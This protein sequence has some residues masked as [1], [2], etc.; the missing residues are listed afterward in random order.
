MRCG[1]PQPLLKISR[2]RVGLVGQRHERPIGDKKA[3]K[4]YKHLYEQM[5]DKETIWQA[6]IDAAEE[7]TERRDVMNALCHIDQTCAET[8]RCIQDPDWQP[9]EHE[10]KH[11]VDGSNGKIREI[12]RPSFCVEQ[13][14]H[15]ALMAPFKPIVLHGMYE[16]VYGSLPSR[17]ITDANGKRRVKKY[18]PQA[19]A[20]QLAKWAQCGEKMF[21]AELDIMGAYAHVVKRILK[22]DLAEAI[23]DPPYLIQMYKCV[24]HMPNGLVLGFYPSPWL[25]NFYFDRFDHWA[26]EF[27]VKYLRYADNLYFLCPNKRRLHRIVAEVQKYLGKNMGMQLKYT[28]Q[29]Y[30]FEYIAGHGADGKPIY[31]GR[32][33]NALGYVIHCDRVTV[34]KSILHNTERKA[35]NIAKKPKATWYDAHCMLARMGW[36]KHANCRKWVQRRIL[37]KVSL[38]TLKRMDSRHAR[39]VAQKYIRKRAIINDRLESS[40]WLAGRKAC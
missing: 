6:V 29:V 21:V 5:V 35:L 37:T 24:D 16:Q 19:A 17:A 4:T 11:I 33:I 12:I 25:F 13:V 3:M 2:Y 23:R 15:H 26:A 39:A 7:K 20:E 10:P 1:C 31:R 30:R 8:L 22:R 38:R 9:P 18:G 32:A 34:R 36:L 40:N 14:W 27:D 28:R